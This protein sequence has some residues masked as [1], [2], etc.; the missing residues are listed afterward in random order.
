MNFPSGSLIQNYAQ[1]SSTTEPG[2]FDGVTCSVLTDKS[3]GT[4]NVITIRNI[5][6][7]ESLTIADGKQSGTWD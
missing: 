7:S 2:K 5:A 1:W 3:E 4:A 6:E